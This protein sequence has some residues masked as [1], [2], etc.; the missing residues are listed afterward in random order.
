MQEMGGKKCARRRKSRQMD[1]GES[2]IKCR[3]NGQRNKN[4]CSNFG[5]F[6]KNLANLENL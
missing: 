3:G 5:F 2:G 4:N 6:A 1:E